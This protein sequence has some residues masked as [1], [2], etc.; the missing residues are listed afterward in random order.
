MAILL[1]GIGTYAESATSASN[2]TYPWPSGYTAT[3]DD[4][5]L[6]FQTGY[7]NNSG[8]LINTATG[9]TR[10]INQHWFWTTNTNLMCQTSY[11]VLNGTESAPICTTSSSTSSGNGGTPT[12]YAGGFVA[13][14]RFVA[15][16]TIP[17]QETPTSSNGTTNVRTPATT[18]LTPDAVTTTTP[19]ARVF[20]VVCSTQDSSPALGTANGFTRQRFSNSAV[21]QGSIAMADYEKASPG[22]VTMPAWSGSSAVWVCLT[23]SLTASSGGFC[24]PGILNAF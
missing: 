20:S 19:D 17:A 3:V 23:F 15:A 4:I 2:V 18:S 8:N 22:A 24:V 11:K 21:Q 6:I 9:Y 12:G 7:S 13:V 14:Y 10:F 1:V 16:T 5:A